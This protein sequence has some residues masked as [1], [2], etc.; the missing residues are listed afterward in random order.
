MVY[1]HT[2]ALTVKRFTRPHVH[3]NTYIYNIY[4]CICRLPGNEVPNDL[5]TQKLKKKTKTE[6]KIVFISFDDVPEVNKEQF[7]GSSVF[8]EYELFSLNR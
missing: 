1:A 2:N 7:P 4:I 3:T 6:M 8:T 5:K